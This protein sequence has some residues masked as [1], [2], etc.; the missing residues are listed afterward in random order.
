MSA[1]GTKKLRFDVPVVSA[2]VSS[3]HAMTKDSF[4]SV[5]ASEPVAPLPDP[6]P[7]APTVSS[8]ASISMS[9]ESGESDR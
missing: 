5:A 4:C 7:P 6:F 2:V 3:E 9:P 8:T 1:Y